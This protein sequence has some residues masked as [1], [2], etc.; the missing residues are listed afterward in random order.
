MSLHR[1]LLNGIFLISLASFLLA[2]MDTLGKYLMQHELHPMQVIWARYSFHTLLIAI[3][4]GRRHYR[5][6]I[7]P[8]RPRLQIVR[9]SFLLGVTTGMYFSL[10]E[11]PLSDATTIMFVAPVLVTLLAALI[12]KESVKQLHWLAL[13]VG[14]IGIL[15][16]IQ[17]EFSDFNP[18]YLLPLAS[19][20]LLAFYFIFTRQLKGHDKETT[21]LFH[22]TA[23]GSIL[24]SVLVPFFWQT[25]DWQGW[26][27]LALLGL[28]GAAGHLL[29]IRAFQ[30]HHA[31]SLSPFLNI[32]ILAATIYGVWVFAE[33]L[34]LS[35][36]IGAG[37]ITLAGLIT[38]Y[39]DHKN[40][41]VN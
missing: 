3:L 34:T 8:K 28:L 13:A 21:T 29:L 10:R 32:Q 22:T 31:S 23:T 24:M 15:C 33:S 37:L 36:T 35:F 7:S 19:S 11:I 40:N 26:S 41:A 30:R 25:V 5:D 27:I 12:L 18:A 39:Q 16:V 6:F 4:F 17:P 20:I 38:W 1:G 14:F 9:G 2:G